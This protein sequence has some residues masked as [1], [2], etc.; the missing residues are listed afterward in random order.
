[1]GGARLRIL[2]IAS[3]ELTVFSK[4]RA[5]NGLFSH[6]ITCAGALWTSEIP[7]GAWVVTTFDD[8]HP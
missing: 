2:I 1:M 8:N 7:V 4:I 5:T 6:I 3:S